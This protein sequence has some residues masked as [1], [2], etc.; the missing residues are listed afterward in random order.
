MVVIMSKFRYESAFDIISFFRNRESTRDFIKYLF[1]Q[2]IEFSKLIEKHGNNKPFPI[3]Y[4]SIGFSY[5]IDYQFMIYVLAKWVALKT[6]D[7]AKLERVLRDFALTIHGL[8]QPTTKKN[9]QFLGVFFGETISIFTNRDREKESPVDHYPSFNQKVI[10][11]DGEYFD[12]KVVGINRHQMKYFVDGWDEYMKENDGY[13]FQNTSK[14]AAYGKYKV[15]ALWN[16]L[17][18]ENGQKKRFY[19]GINDSDYLEGVDKIWE[20]N[21]KA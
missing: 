3:Q 17:K 10:E 4:E 1:E 5:Q 12:Y 2:S 14:Q 19:F 8:H 6:D 20:R 15:S 21:A 18:E 9:I 16:K 13:F 7:K 11:C